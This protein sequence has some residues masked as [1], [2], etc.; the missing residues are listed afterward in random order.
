MD[1]ESDERMTEKVVVQK[2]KEFNECVSK[3]HNNLHLFSGR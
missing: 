1:E 3:K 2:K